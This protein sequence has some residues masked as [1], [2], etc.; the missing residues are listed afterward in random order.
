[1]I[2]KKNSPNKMCLPMPGSIIDVCYRSVNA[3]SPS[4]AVRCCCTTHQFR[5]ATLLIPFFCCC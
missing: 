2:K 3:N 5:P 4:P 1:M